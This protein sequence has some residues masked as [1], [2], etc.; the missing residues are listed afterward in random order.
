MVSKMCPKD[1]KSQREVLWSL[2]TLK[3]SSIQLLASLHLSAYKGFHR[4]TLLLASGGGLCSS[5]ILY[6]NPTNGSSLNVSG[7]VAPETIAINFS[8]S[9]TLK[10]VWSVLHF[11]WPVCD[12]I[13]LR[14][15][16]L[17]N[18]ALLS[19]VDLPNWIY[20]MM[21]TKNSHLLITAL[22]SSETSLSIGKV[23]SSLWQIQ[24]FKNSNFCLKAFILA[25][26]TVSY[27]S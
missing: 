26:N 9:V 14:M 25:T 19:Y 7:N 11:A 6:Q 8:C 20:F 10:S 4:N 12:Y 18:I 27:L 5:V 1:E 22:V 15:G 17:E 16:H 21:K 13:M 24:V 2:R 3:K 23:L